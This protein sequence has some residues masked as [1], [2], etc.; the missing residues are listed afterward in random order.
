MLDG[1]IIELDLPELVSVSLGDA[2]SKKNKELF[3]N[4]IET[5]QNKQNDTNLNPKEISVKQNNRAKYFN[6]QKSVTKTKPPTTMSTK[7]QP[8]INK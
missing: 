8:Q 5:Q 1:N 3:Q 4:E 6:S 7:Y 2:Q